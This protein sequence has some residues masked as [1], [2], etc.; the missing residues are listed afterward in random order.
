MLPP[1]LPLPLIKPNLWKS[2]SKTKKTSVLQV[3]SQVSMIP[4]SDRL[5]TCTLTTSL[6]RCSC[7]YA[8]SWLLNCNLGSSTVPYN[9]SNWWTYKNYCL[10][11]YFLLNN[12][13]YTF[14]F[15]PL[16]KC[17]LSVPRP[18]FFDGVHMFNCGV[19][20]MY[21]ALWTGHVVMRNVSCGNLVWIGGKPSVK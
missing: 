6:G 4:P 12:L 1:S 3:G 13:Q 8:T 21:L 9:L 14:Y 15:L 17:N 19:S 11:F 7:G 16:P 5:C 10:V 20:G 2:F 18:H